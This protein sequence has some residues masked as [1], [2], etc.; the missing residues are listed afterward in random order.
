[1][2]FIFFGEHLI[3]WFLLL[4]GTIYY[5]FDLDFKTIIWFLSG[6][7]LYQIVEMKIFLKQIKFK[8]RAK[9]MTFS[10]MMESIFLGVILFGLSVYGNLQGLKLLIGMSEL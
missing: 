5:I 1:M 3:F 8:T 9:L 2:R 4:G 7:I 6:A 10:L